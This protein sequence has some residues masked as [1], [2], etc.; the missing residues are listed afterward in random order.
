MSGPTTTLFN[1]LEQILSPD[2]N[3]IGSLSGK[4]IMDRLIAFAGTMDSATAPKNATLRGLDLT[5]G[6]GVSVDLAA[7]EFV[8]FGTASANESALK[9]GAVA[10]LTNLVITPDGA[11]PR[12]ARVSVGEASAD[13]DASIRNILTL[14]ARTITPT[15]VNKTRSPSATVTLTLGTPAANPVA[16][17]TPA[18]H[19]ALWD[20]YVPAAAAS[21][22]AGHLIDLRIQFNPWAT[23]FESLIERGLGFGTSSSSFV[24]VTLNS[25][26]LV[27][28]GAVADVAQRTVLGSSLLIPGGALAANTVYNLY[29]IAR[30]SGDGV[31]KGEADGISLILTT[32]SPSADGTQTVTYNPL[33]TVGVTTHTRTGTGLYLG[34]IHT[35]NASQ[36]GAGG[37]GGPI[38]RD[39]SAMNGIMDPVRGGFPGQ[40]PGFFAPPAINWIDATTIFVGTATFVING[41]VGFRAGANATFA[42][43]LASGEVE[44]ASTWYYIYLRPRLGSA[45]RGIRRDY[46]VV[47]SSEAPTVTG[48]KPTPEAGF[49][50]P[51][52]LF[53]GSF[54]NNAASNIIQFSRAASSVLL[55]G[56]RIATSFAGGDIAIDPAFTTVT[57]VAPTTARAIRLH[58]VHLFGANAA[59]RIL[60][61]SFYPLATIASYRHQ[62]SLRTQNGTGFFPASEQLLIETTAAGAFRMNRSAFAGGGTQTYSQTHQMVGYEEDISAP[63]NPN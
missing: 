51:D 56:E 9:L 2:L 63:L 6:A 30:G 21:I 19:V 29:A 34:T 15:N 40:G 7:G 37:N 46:V 39:G 53:C 23:S 55:T 4:A 12:I 59:D 50:I 42:G 62:L 1:T 43:N 16:P 61:V 27:Q 52:Y 25:G 45:S 44:T 20:V 35:D 26:R 17:A 54:R 49:A 10:A 33:A 48:A 14:P 8:R 13:S 11:N 57:A 22:A 58:V 38:D 3:R 36:F 5:P 24:N 47:F 28:R 60:S 41:F 32:T 31:G 18:G